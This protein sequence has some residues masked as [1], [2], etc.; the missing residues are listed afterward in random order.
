MLHPTCI[1]ANSPEVLHTQEQEA[2]G[3]DGSRGT[4]SP[5]R[6]GEKPSIGDVR[7]G[8][9]SS[10]CLLPSGVT[11][12]LLPTFSFAGASDVGPAGPKSQMWL[13]GLGKSTP[14]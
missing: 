8:T 12:S 9:V 2:R 13:D 3:G 11:P 10:G 14:C 5:G 1:F 4:V 6:G 7:G